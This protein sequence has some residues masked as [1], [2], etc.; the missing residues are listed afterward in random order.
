MYV[1]PR[2]VNEGLMFV[3]ILSPHPP[4]YGPAT[5][6]MNTKI[7]SAPIPMMMKRERTTKS[8]KN[9]KPKPSLLLR[10]GARGGKW[11]IQGHRGNRQ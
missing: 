7:S 10:R 6:S 11:I 1:K 2:R 4:N 8:E 3:N 5:V 9:S